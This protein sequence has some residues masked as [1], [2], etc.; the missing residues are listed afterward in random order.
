MDILAREDP[1]G[2]N[3]E[4]VL[5]K[6]TGKVKNV[7]TGSR[8]S[9]AQIEAINNS[10]AILPTMK[11][12]AARWSEAIDKGDILNVTYYAATRK[13]KN[14]VTGRQ[15]SKYSSRIKKTNRNVAP[16]T[17]EMNEYGNLFGKLIDW[18]ALT[19][20][21]VALASK[22]KL[23]PWG[24]NPRAF[25]DDFRAYLTNLATGGRETSIAKFGEAKADFL[26]NTMQKKDRGGVDSKYIRTFRFDRMDGITPT[27]ERARMTPEVWDLSKRRWMP[28]TGEAVQHTPR[29]AI[30]GKAEAGT[31]LPAMTVITPEL[32]ARFMPDVNDPGYA[33]IKGKM[34]FPMLADRMKVGEYVGR[35]GK[36]HELRGGPDHVDIAD[37]L[38]VVAWAVEGGNVATQLQTAINKT[39]GVGLVVLQSEQAVSG[40]R[41]FG[42]IMIDEL[43]YDA[44]HRKKTAIDTRIREVVKILKSKKNKKTGK[45]DYPMLQDV[46]IKNLDDLAAAHPDMSFDLRGDMFRRIASETH[47]KTGGIFWRDVM[48]KVTDYQNKDGYRSGDIV[49]AIQFEKGDSIVDPKDVGT[50]AHPSYALAVKGRSLGNIKGR[51]SAFQ[52]FRDAFNTMG[53]EKPGRGV[54]SEGKVGANAY[55]SMQ[56]R[57]LTDPIFRQKVGSKSL[58]V[59]SYDKPLEFKADSGPKRAELAKRSEI[60]KKL[61][62]R[63]MPDNAA[64]M[65]AAKK[66]DTSTAQR[67]VDQAAKAAGYT[68][69]PVYHG[70]PNKA[71]N[72]FAKNNPREHD[73]S[74]STGEATHFSTNKETAE[75]YSWVEGVDGQVREGEVREFYLRGK[76]R[77]STETEVGVINAMDKDAYMAEGVDILSDSFSG[78]TEFAVFDSKNIKLTNAVTRDNAG[79]VIPLSERF[80]SSSDDIRYMPDVGGQD[81]LGMFSAAERATVN[82]KQERGSASQML[83]MIKKSGVKQEELAELGLDQFLEGNRKVTKD[84]II[85]HLVENQITVEETVLGGKDFSPAGEIR[86]VSVGEA[87]QLLNESVP[88]HYWREENGSAIAIDHMMQLSPHALENHTDAGYLIRTGGVDV[89]GRP[90]ANYVNPAMQQRQVATKHAS[91]VEPGAVEGSYR[92]LLL[93]LPKE[94]T[95]SARLNKLA[96][97]EYGKPWD[98]L[99]ESQQLDLTDETG[100]PNVYQGGHYGEHPN[101]L[102]HV[103]FND[104]VSDH[105][106]TLNIEEI[107]SDLHQEGRKKGYRDNKAHARLSEELKVAK[108]EYEKVAAEWHEALKSGGGF[109]MRGRKAEAAGRVRRAEEALESIGQVPDFPFKTSWHE[110]AMK[111]MIR[112]AVDNG[113]DAIS[114]TKGETQAKRYDLSKHISEVHYSERNTLKAYDHAG[115]IVIEE[116]GVT[117]EKLPDYI[118]KEAA[119]KLLALPERN[120]SEPWTGMRSLTGQDLKVGGEFHKNLYDR[121]LV[122]MKT[123]KKLGLKV[124]EG[125]LSAVKVSK[126]PSMTLTAIDPKVGK[127]F[128]AHIVRLSPEVKAKVLDGGLARFMPD[129]AAP[130]T[131][132]NQLGWSLIKGQGNKW[133]VYKPNGTLAG[134]AA[135]KASAERMFR[136]KYKRELRKADK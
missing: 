38:G 97:D 34:A 8:F 116:T 132:K 33:S 100:N 98:E 108:S 44:S 75:G 90:D 57:S 23:S 42:D 3:L 126:Y 45:L 66:G 17:V 16:Y 25:I 106:K 128:P 134:I 10:P 28:D 30:N 104:R 95:T 24:N 49:K 114:W 113:Y 87:K 64:Y 70:S 40:N 27:G 55:R 32:A 136:T 54:S 118:G 58:D 59:K 111:R 56:M 68:I 50:P 124:G 15:R 107:Q 26:H 12:S 79:N 81:A 115:K 109:D 86:E 123:W 101:V 77:P 93:R 89:G 29:D 125:E 69:G 41:T 112:Y 73:F 13:V 46:S 102:A 105:G 84:E 7:L 37:N 99:L 47:G 127:S 88:L 60:N 119:D 78:E 19:N 51:L 129:A 96:Q 14:L 61:G 121:K 65:K 5:D 11:Q 94:R 4:K 80:Q 72:T 36:V 22:K 92:E 31:V 2:I 74:V 9:P 62:A 35:S 130:N 117:S 67:M 76:V 1:D 82:L 133:R 48:R 18:T 43:R 110:L 52:V 71:F 39:D 20:D 91:Y 85:D 122:R 103:R 63:H 21:I 120:L 131:L 83:A 6:K 135:T 53:K